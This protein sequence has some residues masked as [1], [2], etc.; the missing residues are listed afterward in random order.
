[1]FALIHK[2]KNQLRGRKV[3]YLEQQFLLK[4][5]LTPQKIKIGSAVSTMKSYESQSGKSNTPL[6]PCQTCE[7]SSAIPDIKERCLD[8]R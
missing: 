7:P 6:P 8:S 1:M 4:L 3:T 5:L 2:N